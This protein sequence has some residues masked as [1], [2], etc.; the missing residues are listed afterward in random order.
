MNIPAAL[1]TR[2]LA[3][4][5][6]ALAL[7]ITTST[8]AQSDDGESNNRRWGNR[9]ITP[10]MRETFRKRIQERIAERKKKL[11]E[12]LGASDEEFEIIFPYIEQIRDLTR[13][14][15]ALARNQSDSR[16]A[17]W[18][19]FMRGDDAEQPQYTQTGT[20]LKNAL[21][22]LKKAAAEKSTTAETY[23]NLIKNVRNAYKAQDAAIQSK[24]TELRSI[25]TAQQEAQL[26]L[27]GVLD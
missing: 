4:L 14:R 18:E 10:E 17:R 2:S 6:L 3:L 19:Q 15:T 20:Q 5:T 21:S 9:E 27:I 26:I 12:D 13:E 1:L 25:L 23:K 11:Q 8:W 7:G 24:R 22:A 16:R